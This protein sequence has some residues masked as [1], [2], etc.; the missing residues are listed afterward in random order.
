MWS[1]IWPLALIVVSNTVYHIMAK[2]TPGSANAFLSLTVT[3]LVGAVLTFIGYIAT[4][5]GKTL[6]QSFPQLNWTS[7][8]LGLAIIGLETGFIYMYRAGWKVSAGPLVANT[9]VALVM[10]GV[11]A[12][13]FK[14]A[15]TIK[16]V[17]GIA[18]CLGGLALV[19]G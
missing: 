1:Y 2:Q 17:I 13:F 3:Y 18:L 6:G 7:F 16:Q 5:Q 9:L 12:L 4:A 14:E 10:V 19:N 15:I 11:G 8:V